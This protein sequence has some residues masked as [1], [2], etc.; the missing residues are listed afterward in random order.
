[1]CR[2]SPLV[3]EPTSSGAPSTPTS[4]ATSRGLA[5]SSSTTV[6]VR[7]TRGSA[8][9]GPLPS[10]VSHFSVDVLGRRTLCHHPE[11]ERGGRRPRTGWSGHRRTREHESR[12]FKCRRCVVAWSPRRR[13]SETVFRRPPLLWPHPESSEGGPSVGRAGG[14]G[15]G[16]TSGQVQGTATETGSLC[17]SEAPKKS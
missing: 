14:P 4:G 8:C 6:P 9:E 13:G 3:R 12:C 5:G 10:R 7:G 2:A 11:T 16:D 17:S 1:M 15:P